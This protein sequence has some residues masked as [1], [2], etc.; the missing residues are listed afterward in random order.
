MDLLLVGCWQ[1][2]SWASLMTVC[3]LPIV[4]VSTYISAPWKVWF[5]FSFSLFAVSEKCFESSLESK[6]SFERLC[7]DFVGWMWLHVTAWHATFPSKVWEMR[8]FL[9]DGAHTCLDSEGDFDVVEINWDGMQ[10]HNG[11][12]LYTL[13]YPLIPVL[14]N[15]CGSERILSLCNDQKVVKS[16][17]GL[18]Y[19]GC[20][21]TCQWNRGR[22]CWIQM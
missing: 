3:H 5:S 19:G 6:F 17:P 9:L 7:S 21:Q 11:G 8:K 15:S 4:Q 1:R 22:R 14:P 16:L 10:F 2:G 20:L 12:L 13:E 18:L